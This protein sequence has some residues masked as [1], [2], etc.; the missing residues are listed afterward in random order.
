MF[1]PTGNIMF[2]LYCFGISPSSGLSRTTDLMTTIFSIEMLENDIVL[3]YS[4]ISYI[5]NRII[6][7]QEP[8]YTRAHNLFIALNR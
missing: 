5:I 1:R 2:F 4:S 6:P 7:E 8:V 3:D